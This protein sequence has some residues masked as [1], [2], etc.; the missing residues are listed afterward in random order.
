M[1]PP[2][3]LLMAVGAGGA[4]GAVARYAATEVAAD[5]SGFPWTTFAINVSGSALLAALLLLPLA[6]RS[7]TWAAALGPGVLGG[8]TT[9]SATSAQ[10]RSLL[11]DGRA[12]LALA[13]VA[14]TLLAC[15]VAVTVVGLAAPPLPGEDEL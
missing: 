9:F 8:Y 14:G 5:G 3:R 11:A 2:P 6:R 10:A 15:L 7:S 13:Y 12:G 4:V 1:T